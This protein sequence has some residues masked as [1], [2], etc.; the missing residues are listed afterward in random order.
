N[1]IIKAIKK[2][3]QLDILVN[4][5]GV[6]FEEQVKTTT[7][8][9]LDK[10]VD[11]NFKGTYLM[12]K[13]FLPLIENSNG[14]IINISSCLGIVPEPSSPAYCATKSAIIMLTKCLA[15]EYASKEIRVNVICPGPIDTSLLRN[16]FSSKEDMEKSANRNPMKRF[17]KPEEVA[18]IAVFLASKEAS[19]VTGGVYSVDGGVSSSSVYSK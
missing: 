4:N 5:A 11:T 8:S 3:K 6:Y 13:H 2:I 10:M 1:Q 18:N 14:N 15:Q 9:Q 12:C 17:G 16:I 19:Y 7:T